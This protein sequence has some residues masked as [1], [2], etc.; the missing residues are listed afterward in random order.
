MRSFLA[1][2]AA[3]LIAAPAAAIELNPGEFRTGLTEAQAQ[4][5]VEANQHKGTVQVSY[6]VIL[7]TWTVQLVIDNG[8]GHDNDTVAE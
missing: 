2:A 1:L 7:G 6:D 3:A 8:N 5:A 4:A